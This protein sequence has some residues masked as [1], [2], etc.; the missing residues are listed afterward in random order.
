[1][2]TSWNVMLHSLMYRYWSSVGTAPTI[3]N[4]EDGNSRFF[5]NT[6]RKRLKCDGTH[7]QKPHFVFRRN[8]RVHLNQRGRQFRRLLAAEV[9]ASAVVM[10]DTPRSEVVWRVLATNSICQFPLHFPSLCHRV[11]SH[12]NWTLSINQTLACLTV[13]WA[14]NFMTTVSC[15]K[16][17]SIP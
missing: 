10:L 6:G 15:H 9:R 13:M 12:F 16:A 1:M 2:E 14:W 5:C 7:A 4:A 17:H 11:P 3:T 8:G